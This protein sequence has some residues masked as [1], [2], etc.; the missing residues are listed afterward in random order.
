D[1]SNVSIVPGDVL[2]LDLA[3][4]TGG[5]RFHVYG[6]LPYYI[7]SPILHRLFEHAERIASINVIVQLE[8]AVRI[9]AKPGRR[10]YGYLSVVTQ[11]YT[12]PEIALR[13]PPGAFQPR[14]KVSSALVRMTLPGQRTHLHIAR[15]LVQENV[16]S[17]VPKSATTP[18]P[19]V[20]SALAPSSDERAFLKFAGHCF[21]QKRKTIANNLRARFP[22]PQ[23]EAALAAAAIKRQA[24]AEEL[25][26][27]DFAALF[28]QLRLATDEHG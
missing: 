22:A 6:S 1:M 21:E 20:A 8:V 2:A 14:P 18:A 28:R 10:D 5:A 11:F 7:T 26:L 24:R 9:T 23:V 19:A 15:E 4:I 12:Q 13:L 16:G 3:Q 27:R 17:P 25:S